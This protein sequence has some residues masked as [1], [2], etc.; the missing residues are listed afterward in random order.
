MLKLPDYPQ[1]QIALDF[2]GPLLSDEKLFW[3]KYFSTVEI[4]KNI[5]GQFIQNS[6][7][8]NNKHSVTYHNI[9]TGGKL[10]LKRHDK[11]TKLQSEY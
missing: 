4:M 11:E 3:W 5:S 6:C 2:Y 1:S 9:E 7:K 10:I 8:F